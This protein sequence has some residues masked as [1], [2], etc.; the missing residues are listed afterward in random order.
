[1]ELNILAPRDSVKHAFKE[2]NLA[3]A[4][5]LVFLSGLAGLFTAFILGVQVNL[6]S[7]L[8]ASEIRVFARFAAFAILLVIASIVLRR[9]AGDLKGMLSALSLLSLVN[10]IGT[11]IVSIGIILFVPGQAVQETLAGIGSG[12]LF[13]TVNSLQF[14][15]NISFFGLFMVMLAA[16][17]LFALNFVFFCHAIKNYL[18][19]SKWGSIV[20]A[21]LALG[22]LSLLPI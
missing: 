14:G 16:I 7:L 3:L 15:S 21:L 22:V 19:I 10:L 13:A 6:T 5:L 1:M 18:S 12:N 17:A 2:P 9:N 20:L 8:V 11:I 4:L